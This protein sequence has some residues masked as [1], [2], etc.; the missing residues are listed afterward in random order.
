LQTRRIENQYSALLHLVQYLYEF[1][2]VC[3]FSEGAQTKLNHPSTVQ[4][5]DS[6]HNYNDRKSNQIVCQREQRPDSHDMT[7][8]IIKVIQA[9]YHSIIFRA[10]N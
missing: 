8:E 10:T 2:R 7:H 3:A 9:I 1:Y 6:C 4:Y 5:T